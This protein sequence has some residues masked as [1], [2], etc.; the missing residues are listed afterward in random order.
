MTGFFFCQSRVSLGNHCREKAMSLQKS[1][2]AIALLTL[3]LSLTVAAQVYR[4]VDE[5][6]NV[7]YT[8][9]PPANDT[10]AE[11]LTLP[12]INTQPAVAPK[13][14]TRSSQ[15]EEVSYKDIVI[16]SPA[17]DS[18]I[19]PGQLEVVVQVY[20][21]PALRSG[22]RVQLRHNGQPHGPAVPATSFVIDSLIRGAHTLQAQVVDNTDNPI[23]QSDT[24]T[25]HVKRHSILH[26]P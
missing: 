15:S 5:K 1:K 9:Q 11:E 13:K 8:D 7:K 22:H 24:V 21:E 25:I 14:P 23:G 16:L 17:Q 19:P 3:M 12:S 18:T 20:L 6:G 4:T 10:S 2:T 26:N